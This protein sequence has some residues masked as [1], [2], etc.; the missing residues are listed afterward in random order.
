MTM[1]TGDREAVRIDKWLWAARFFKTRALAQ[2][3]LENGRVLLGGERVK[4]AR[5]V[6]V[7]EEVTIRVGDVERIVVV[8]ALSAVR[9]PAPVAQQLYR[10]TPDSIARRE[11]Q[12]ASRPFFR[13]PADAISPGQMSKKDRRQ[14]RALREHD[15]SGDDDD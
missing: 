8:Q 15:A 9:G 10:E 3:A 11:A 14:L 13:D 4:R 12:R 2:T 5:N 7:G 6:Q 1:P